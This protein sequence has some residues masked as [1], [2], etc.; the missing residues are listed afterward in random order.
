MFRLVA[1]AGVAADDLLAQNASGR[2]A[3][4][5]TITA[6]RCGST[7]ACGSS[8]MTHLDLLA[9][10]PAEPV[11]MVSFELD[12]DGKARNVGVFRSHGLEMDE[13]AIEA[14]R[15]LNFKPAYYEDGSIL[16]LVPN[17]GTIE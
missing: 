10:T 17:R 13:K 2:W 6:R 12:L 7:S 11:V 5:S 3:G 8:R 4:R 9:L 15:K 14:V 1:L 16:R